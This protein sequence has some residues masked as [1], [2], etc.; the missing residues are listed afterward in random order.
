MMVGKE[1]RFIVADELPWE[2]VGEGVRRKIGAYG[3]DL[4]AVLVEFRKGSIGYLHKHPHR[5][6]TYIQSGAFE[7]TIGS[8]KK[9]LRGGDLYYI[10]ADIDHGVTALEDSFLIDMFTPHRADF[11]GQGKQ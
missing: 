9:I 8:E 7:V 10:P 11:V 5:Q 3:D 6:I 1:Q 4:M 2:T